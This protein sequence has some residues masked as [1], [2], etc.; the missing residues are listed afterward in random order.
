MRL[1]ICVVYASRSAEKPMAL[2]TAACSGRPVVIIY[3]KIGVSRPTTITVTIPESDTHR[4][5]PKSK[6][7]LNQHRTKRSQ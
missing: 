2:I 4:M 7:T 3:S 1:S 6:R 5:E